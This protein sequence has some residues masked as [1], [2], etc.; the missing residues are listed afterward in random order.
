MGYS[1]PG[2]GSACEVALMKASRFD[3][4][5]VSFFS[6]SVGTKPNLFPINIDER[7]PALPM[8][9][10]TSKTTRARPRRFSIGLV[11]PVRRAPQ[12]VPPIL[13]FDFV[14]MGDLFIRPFSGLNEPDQALGRISRPVQAD[15]DVSLGGK[16][17]SGRASLD[18][19]PIFAATVA[20]PRQ[21]SCYAVVRQKRTQFLNWHRRGFHTTAPVLP[22]FN[23]G[24]S[25]TFSRTGNDGQPNAGSLGVPA[26]AVAR[27]PQ[28]KPVAGY[29]A[30]PTTGGC[31]RH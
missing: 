15:D 14:S 2:S 24:C 29:A 12:I 27:P 28:P 4:R 13:G 1:A 26:V 22:R 6:G 21:K 17:A 7:S 25:P 10:N 19:F 9:R 31:H 3:V 20:L 5:D 16:T 18:P 23:H 11:L 30:I 8:T